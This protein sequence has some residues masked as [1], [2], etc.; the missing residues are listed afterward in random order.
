M[1]LFTARWIK[2][3]KKNTRGRLELRSSARST[4]GNHY[5]NCPSQN[6]LSFYVYGSEVKNK[7]CCEL[8]AEVVTGFVSGSDSS[9]CC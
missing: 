9:A 1:Y 8:G 2:K 6:G 3:A 5:V 4:C 7:T